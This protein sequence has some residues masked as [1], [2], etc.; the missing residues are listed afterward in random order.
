MCSEMSMSYCSLP[1]LLY[2]QV[3]TPYLCNCMALHSQLG[4]NYMVGLFVA[5]PSVN[6]LISFPHYH[7]CFIGGISWVVLCIGCKHNNNTNSNKSRSNLIQY[8]CGK[9]S[10][11]WHYQLHQYQRG[12]WR[13][14]TVQLNDHSDSNY[15]TLYMYLTLRIPKCICCP[16]I[17]VYTHIY[18]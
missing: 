14:V 18:K 15:K 13:G 7:I 6:S 2:V 3:I 16:T 8:W 9:A 11:T 12:G 5:K 1:M 17:K 10:S 4:K